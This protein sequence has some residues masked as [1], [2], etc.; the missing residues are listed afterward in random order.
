MSCISFVREH[1][2]YHSYSSTQY[3]CKFDEIR[4]LD[5]INGMIFFFVLLQQWYSVLYDQ[6]LDQLPYVCHTKFPAYQVSKY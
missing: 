6:S 5:E 4:I 1:A 2:H 3:I